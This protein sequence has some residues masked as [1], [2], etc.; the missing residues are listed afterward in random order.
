MPRCAVPCAHAVVL[1]WGGCCCCRCCCQEPALWALAGPAVVT[2]FG[3]IL[4]HGQRVVLDPEHHGVCHR[5]RVSEDL[6]PRQMAAAGDSNASSGPG[7]VRELFVLSQP[8]GH[9]VFH[10][11]AECLP[12]VFCLADLSGR[13]LLRAQLLQQLKS[14]FLRLPPSFFPPCSARPR[15]PACMCACRCGEMLAGAV[16]A[17]KPARWCM[18]SPLVLTCET[19]TGAWRECADSDCAAR[20]AT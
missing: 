16:C 1:K 3:A 7:W 11:L 19:G 2:R 9:T 5:M 18:R 10:F 20:A 13:V 12:K 6:S 8:W 4:A 14:S 15:T 17:W